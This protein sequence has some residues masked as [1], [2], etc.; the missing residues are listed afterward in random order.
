M[1]DLAS[2]HMSLKVPLAAFFHLIN[3]MVWFTIALTVQ[4][5]DHMEQS[6]TTLQ[7]GQVYNI[8]AS[9]ILVTDIIFLKEFS[10]QK[11]MILSTW[12]IQVVSIR[13]I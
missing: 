7:L 3:K 4:Y 1:T 2:L 10:F 9:V 8:P 13:L 6:I 5:S 12:Y 11:I